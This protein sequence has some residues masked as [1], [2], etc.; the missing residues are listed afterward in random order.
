M[1]RTGKRT[2]TGVMPEQYGA[3]LSLSPDEKTL[4]VTQGVSPQTEDIWLIDLNR[5]NKARFTFGYGGQNPQWTPDG[6]SIIYSHVVGP[7]NDIVRKPIAGGI[8]EVLARALV[9]GFT[10]DVSPDGK[11]IVYQMSAAKTGFDIGLISLDDSHRTS[12]YLG[13]PANERSAQFSPDGKWMAYQSDESGRNEVY[14]Q[15]IP[16]GGK[17][18]QISTTGGSLPVWRRDGQE[19]FFL[20]LDQKIISVPLRINGA[21]L[22][23]GTPQELFSV[24]GA[25]GFTIPRDAQRFLINFPAGGEAAV[26]PPITVLTNWQSAL[27]K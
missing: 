10:S 25:L 27:K 3:S 12:V 13:T 1:D 8:E 22:D 2:G 15:T 18:Y 9:N 26:A 4:A 7:T 20:S 6:A 16:I 11:Q 14:I 5:T 21:T 19:L 24:P 17:K 23:P